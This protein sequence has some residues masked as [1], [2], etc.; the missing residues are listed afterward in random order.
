MDPGN[1]VYFTAPKNQPG[2]ADPRHRL[3]TEG[4]EAVAHRFNT[5]CVLV[6]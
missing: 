1:I 6:Q 3:P 5:M 4:L 2:V